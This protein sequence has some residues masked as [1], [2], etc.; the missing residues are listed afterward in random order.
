M[1][2]RAARLSDA[3]VRARRCRAADHEFG[4]ARQASAADPPLA[5]LSAAARRE[6]GRCRTIGSIWRRPSPDNPWR[7][8]DDEF[9]DPAE[10]QSRHYNEFVTFLP[11]VQ[12]FLYGQGIGRSVSKV[13]GESPIRVMRR[14]DVARRARHP[15]AGRRAGRAQGRARRSLFLLRYRHRAPGD[16]GLRRRYRLRDRAEPAVPVRARLS[17]LLGKRTAAAAIA[18]GRSNGSLTTGGYLRPPTTRTARNSCRMSAGT[19]RRRLPRTGSTCCRRWCCITPTRRGL[20]L[21]AARILPHAVH[22]LPVG[23]PRRYDYSLR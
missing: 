5:R 6:G 14:T 7:E 16:R 1:R 20:A 22:G 18:R 12:R 11:P 13:Y 23:R 9:G 10:F 15:N 3:P 21:P 8:V 17:G 4:K 2:G 19:V